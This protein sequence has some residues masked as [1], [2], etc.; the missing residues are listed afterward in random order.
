MI[1]L[2]SSVFGVAWLVFGITEPLN[3]TLKLLMASETSGGRIV[4]EY[5][6]FLGLFL[7]FG[8]FLGLA[9]NYLS[10]LIFS[11]LTKNVNEFEE[12]QEG[13]IGV[14]LII[15]AVIVVISL[16]CREPFIYFLESFMPYPELPGF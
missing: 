12:I 2:S 13:N 6:K 15:S 5:I 10:F 4:M 16:F 8:Y 3:G 9:I 1:F 11:G 7:F 14:A